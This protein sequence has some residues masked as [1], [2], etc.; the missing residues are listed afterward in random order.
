MINFLSNA[1]TFPTVFYTGLLILVFLYWLISA[2]GFLEFEAI[3]TDVDSGEM[4]GIAAWL[5]KFRLNGIPFTLTLSLVIFISWVLCL[6]IVPLLMKE[7][8]SE[9]VYI[10]LGFWILI[11]AP[12]L[13]LPVTAILLSP[14]RHLLKKLRKNN[15]PPTAESFIGMSGKIRSEKVN[16]SYGTAEIADG[17]AGLILQIRADEPNNYQRN[18]DIILTSYLTATN[19]YLIR[20]Q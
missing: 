15:L 5:T 16:Q 6:F 18:D 8:N 20:H 3:E 12:T 14:L 11:L 4:G 10:A 17:G 1:L 19:T 13:A 2:F 9:W 7:I